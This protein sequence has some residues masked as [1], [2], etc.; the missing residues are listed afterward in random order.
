MNN[1]FF[2]QIFNEAKRVT[3]EDFIKKAKV[4][5]PDYDYSKVQYIDS[6]TPIIIGCPKHGYFQISPNN[7][8]NRGRCQKCGEEVYSKKKTLTNDKFIKKAKEIY[9]DYDYSKT[10]YKKYSDKVDVICPKHGMFT[11]RAGD[12]LR[13]GCPEC[14]KENSNGNRLNKEEAINRLKTIL[15]DYDFSESNYVDYD[16]PIKVTCPKH[17]VFYNTPRHFF[18]GT[19]CH[20]CGID[21]KIKRFSSNSEEFIEKAKRIHPEYDYSEVDYKNAKSHITI[22]CPKHGPFITT[23]DMF[24]RGCG[25]P[26]C[27]E[28]KGERAIREW[29][30][31][32]KINF[33]DQHRFS[34]LKRYPYDFFLPDY[35]L[36]IEYN[37][38]QHYKEIPDFFHREKGC[39]EGQLMRDKIKKDYA[40]KNGYDLLVIPYWEF[41]NIDTILSKKLLSN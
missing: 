37:G 15:P 24:L 16:T 17:G 26:R 38:E 27:S 36:I 28:S 4:I 2:E 5:Q 22:T 9:P 33:S 14:A 12:F 34:D 35:N 31:N 1:T 30:K 10:I 11:A 41:K 3:T 32:Q 25:C 13:R 6:R 23:P 18:K 29:L 7:F 39:F 8:L 21:K 19:I 40:E 20:K